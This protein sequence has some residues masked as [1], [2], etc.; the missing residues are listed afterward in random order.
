MVLVGVW[1]AYPTFAI[2]VGFGIVVGVAYIWR[3]MQKAFFAE[4]GTGPATPGP[5]LP[6]PI[7]PGITKSRFEPSPEIWLVICAWT[8]V[9]I[10]TSRMTAAL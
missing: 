5:P 2:C 6:L 10:D 9:P 3:A 4:A 7:L 8:P 1:R